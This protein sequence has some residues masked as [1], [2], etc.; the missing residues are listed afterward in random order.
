MQGVIL[1]TIAGFKPFF[2]TL[3]RVEKNGAI[4]NFVGKVG[5]VGGFRNAEKDDA[6]LELS[7]YPPFFSNSNQVNFFG[8][9]CNSSAAVFC[10]REGP[11]NTLCR[12]YF[13]EALSVH[14]PLKAMKLEEISLTMKFHDCRQ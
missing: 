5:R 3:M 2:F 4:D 14:S 9:K 11:R 12:T 10:W 6:F 7:D 8:H 13:K 1:F